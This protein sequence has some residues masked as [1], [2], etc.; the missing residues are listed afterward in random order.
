ML[1]QTW[2]FPSIKDFL[3][4]ALVKGLFCL[5]AAPP[6]IQ[7]PR[8]SPIFYTICCYASQQRLQIIPPSAAA[9]DKQPPAQPSGPPARRVQTLH[10]TRP[11]KFGT[12]CPGLIPSPPSP[13]CQEARKRCRGRARKSS[14]LIAVTTGSARAGTRS[15]CAN[16]G[17]IQTRDRDL[18]ADT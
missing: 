7:E 12:I 18:L 9:A 17:R 6:P 5:L 16:L 8:K 3:H 2:D 15:T 10:P 11:E 14:F 13:E 4:I 1:E